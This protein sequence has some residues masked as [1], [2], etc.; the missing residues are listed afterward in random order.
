MTHPPQEVL[1][2]VMCRERLP[3]RNSWY[4]CVFKSRL[5]AE[6]FFDVDKRA[7]V[8]S[9]NASRV[10]DDIIAWYEPAT[11]IVL[12]EEEYTELESERLAFK[13]FVQWMFD[14]KYSQ[15]ENVDIPSET[16]RFIHNR[17][18]YANP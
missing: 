18:G 14:H 3:D 10:Y 15:V 7:F 9:D 2:K 17:L 4:V 11:R 16:I 5:S 13:D 8:Y 6:C 1:V 12:T